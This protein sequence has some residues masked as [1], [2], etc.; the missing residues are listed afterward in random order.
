MNTFLEIL[1]YTLP[2]VVVLL[3][4]Y[5]TIDKFFNHEKDQKGLEIKKDNQKITLPLRLQAYERI[6]LFLERISPEQLLLRVQKPGI[7]VSQLQKSLNLTIRAEYEHNLSQQIYVSENA[8]ELVKS[9]KENL[10]KIINMASNSL[11]PD[12]KGIV[13]SKKII[14]VFSALEKSP[15]TASINDI[16][17]E[18]A[19]LL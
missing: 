9:S 7:S 13:L 18:A 1:K 14:E 17:K 15:I 8:W 11:K 2:S 6:I 16:K 10:I 4:A 3:T 5:Y 19:S 12:D